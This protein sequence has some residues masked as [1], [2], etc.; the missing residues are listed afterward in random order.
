MRNLYKLICA[1][2]LSAS[3][4]GCTTVDR[5]EHYDQG[6]KKIVETLEERSRKK[7]ASKEE[8]IE[9]KLNAPVIEGVVRIT[10]KDSSCTPQQVKEYFPVYNTSKHYVRGTV[11]GW[12]SLTTKKG[13]SYAILVDT[14]QGVNILYLLTNHIVEQNYLRQRMRCGALIDFGIGKK[15]PITDTF[16]N[17]QIIFVES[18]GG[19]K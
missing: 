14:N 6:I 9:E 5:N 2:T 12:S 1:A 7:N 8:S 17:P 18:N 11:V 15:D 16:N 13:D 19:T 4:Y 10:P 3:L